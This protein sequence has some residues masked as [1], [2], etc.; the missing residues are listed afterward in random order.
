MT[1]D[2]PSA[3]VAFALGSSGVFLLVGMLCGVWKWRA[4]LDSAAHTAPPYVDLAH[5]AALLYSFACVV[6]AALARYSPYPPWLTLASTAGPI[7]FF[8]IAVGTYLLLGARGRL[9]TQFSERTFVTTTGTLV[10]AL[11]EI[12]GTA[13]LLG[14]FLWTVLHR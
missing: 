1:P 3:S 4:M 13:A 14:G 12:A 7:V 8:A 2:A 9:E 5:R 10:L 11:V 6:L